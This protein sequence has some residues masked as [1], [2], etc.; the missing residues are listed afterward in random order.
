MNREAAPR[1]TLGRS[2]LR[3]EDP[4]LL[5]GRGEF[6]GDIGFPH[7]LHVHV[8][9]SPYAHAV[10]LRVDVADKLAPPGEQ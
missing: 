1:P 2:L 10:L 9:R 3:L 6:V 8:V 7:Q 4:S 5:T